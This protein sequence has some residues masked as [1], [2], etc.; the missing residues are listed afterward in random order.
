MTKKLLKKPIA[1]A[2]VPTKKAI[3]Q[4]VIVHR[5][6]DYRYPRGCIDP[7]SRKSFRTKIRNAIYKMEREMSKL[8]GEPLKKHKAKLGAYI[9]KYKIP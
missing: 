4:T 6:L 7:L 3:L 9:S 8:S 1:K 5:K 2:E